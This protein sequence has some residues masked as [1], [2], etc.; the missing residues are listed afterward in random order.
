MGFIGNLKNVK[1]I[2]LLGAGLLVG[3][4][5]IVIGS[6]DYTLGRPKE[7]ETRRTDIIDTSDYVEKLERQVAALI[8]R[9]DGAGVASVLITLESD[10]EHVY[11]Y[12]SKNGSREYLTIGAGTSESPVLLRRMTPR[13]RGIAVVCSGGDNPVVQQKIISMLC[14]LFDLPSTKVFVSG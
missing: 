14:A 8:E 4:A 3:I 10:S 13:L 5:L 2:W 12:D 1:G 7:E 9:I 6:V 11:A